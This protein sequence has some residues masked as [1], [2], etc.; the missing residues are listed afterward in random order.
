MSKRMLEVEEAKI[1][2]VPE[3]FLQEIMAGN[4][5]ENITSLNI[6]GWGSDVSYN[7][8]FLHTVKHRMFD[9]HCSGP[10]SKHKQFR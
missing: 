1:Q 8:M 6:A 3:S 2:V 9:P 7:Q 10:W 5:I 4:A